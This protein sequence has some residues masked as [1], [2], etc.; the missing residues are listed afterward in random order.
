M[1]QLLAFTIHDLAH[2]DFRH[3][4]RKQIQL[5]SCAITLTSGVK[6]EEV[7]II[8][9]CNLRSDSHRMMN[10]H[11]VFTMISGELNTGNLGLWGRPRSE[12]DY[13]WRLSFFYTMFRYQIM[14][15]T[16][17]TNVPF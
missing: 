15:E 12:L 10:Y 13:T 11:F 14:E 17:Q 6:V 16:G 4:N 1:G 5:P 8:K 9:V 7:P 3:N 2:T